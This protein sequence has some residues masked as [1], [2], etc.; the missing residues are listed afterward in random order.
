MLGTADAN[1]TYNF[2]EPLSFALRRQ[3]PFSPRP[4]EGSASPVK[5]LTFVFVFGEMVTLLWKPYGTHKYDA[6][7]KLNFLGWKC[8][9][10]S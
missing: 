10:Y 6:W 8:D 5:N 4:L 2:L 7:A 3:V 9:M 1:F